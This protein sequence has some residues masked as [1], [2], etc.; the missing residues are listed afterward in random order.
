M[1]NGP[2]PADF[3]PEDFIA[4]LGHR[5]GVFRKGVQTPLVPGINALHPGARS[6]SRRPTPSSTPH[7]LP[8]DLF[9]RNLL[10]DGHDTSVLMDQ[11][12][13]RWGLADLPADAATLS[14]LHS[15]WL[16]NVPFENATK[17]IRMAET[18]H[19]DAAR[20]L[21][22]R[23]WREHLESG[24]GGTC[25]AASSAFRALLEHAGYA[26]RYVFCRMPREKQRAHVAILV[27]TAEG[28]HLVDVGYALPAPV[29]LPNSFA[30]RRKTPYYDAEIRRGPDGG[31]LVLSTDDRGTRFRYG[32][33]LECVSED[34]FVAA[35][36]A[37]FDPRAPYMRRLALGRF[38]GD[39][40]YIY[41]PPDRLYLIG[42]AR[43]RSVRFDP[44]GLSL[45]SAVFRIP[46]DILAAAEES[47]ETV[48]RRAGGS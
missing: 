22:D 40:R 23:F 37:T 14:R 29:P 39:S 17:L 33:N 35:W 1:S 44:P 10:E 38:T 18:G 32:F 15:A 41:K 9:P 21:P 34:A 28:R 46:V 4:D 8:L 20:R 26:C 7:E 11:V 12:L 48:R 6:E 13:D 5:P 43:Q 27:E 47:L 2:P 45:L 42:R 36:N 31:Y 19:A 24:T 3:E 25:Y 30:A 16:M